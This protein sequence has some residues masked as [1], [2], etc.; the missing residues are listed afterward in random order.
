[1]R[2][3]SSHR[4]AI[5]LVA[6]GS[7]QVASA[8][9][10]AADKLFDEGRAL[11]HAHKYVEACAAFAGSQKLDPQFGTLFNLADCETELG[12]LAT[13][14]QHYREL[15]RA[16]PNPDRRAASAQAAARLEP[17]LPKLVIELRDRPTG[18]A[19]T[20]DGN[21]VLPLIGEPMP[22]DVGDH[23]VVASAPGFIDQHTTATAKE[24]EVAHVQLALAPRPESEPPRTV[25]P[26]APPPVA[27]PPLVSAKPVP[28]AAP[29]PGLTAR[30]PARY[31]TPAKIALI[32]GG[33]GFVVGLV[34]GGIALVQFHH[35]KT[36][37]GCDR[38]SASHS[39]VVWGDVSTAL[40][41]AGAIP[42]VVGG[43]YLWRTS[44]SS[45][46][47]VPAASP[48]GGGAVIVGRF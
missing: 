29:T 41:I 32:G 21:D 18:V 17:K 45:A 9:P 36:C 40:V 6:I 10:T 12:R 25:T 8:E 27:P 7:L 43:V 4:L 23:I 14:W 38:P 3:G 46:A 33:G 2:A 1:V 47:I 39:A 37:T 44:R 13:A 15:A 28:S 48:E 34:F 5:G 22:V 30:A 11:L 26:V 31:R 42:A 16:D 24:R 19:V 20:L 35:A